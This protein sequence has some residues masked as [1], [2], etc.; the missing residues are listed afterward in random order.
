MNTPSAVPYTVRMP[1]FCPN[2][3]SFANP[4]DYQEAMCKYEEE[5]V[6]R[7]AY[8]TPT[9]SLNLN[10][11]FENEDEDDDDD[12]DDSNSDYYYDDDESDF[13]FDFDYEENPLLLVV[14]YKT[15]KCTTEELQTSAGECS[16]CLEDMTRA[17]CVTT[18]CMH[19]YCGPCYNKYKKLTCPLCRQRVVYF[20]RYAE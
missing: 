13:D 5:L 14:P 11:D 7:L 8:V 18:N 16:I 19:S 1:L 20:T 3:A 2:R 17:N 12:D 6:K 9:S 15:Q 10:P 4:V